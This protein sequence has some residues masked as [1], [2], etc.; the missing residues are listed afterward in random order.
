MLEADAQNELSRRLAGL[1]CDIKVPRALQERLARRGAL[2]TT[3]DE[4]RKFV[5]FSALAKAL[6]EV[7]SSIQH[8]DRAAREFAVLRTDL[9]GEGLGFLHAA[10]LFPGDL[11]TV[12]FPTGKLDCRVARCVKHTTK[13]F[14]IGATFAAGTRSLR[15]LRAQ[16]GDAVVAEA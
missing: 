14:E 4:R 12:W 6:L 10:Q 11:V 16:C 15:W 7:K 2:P 1:V 3:Y 8:G 5:R 13:C 9:S